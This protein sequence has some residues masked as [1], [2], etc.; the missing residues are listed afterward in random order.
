MIA[1]GKPGG[2]P[3]RYKG[4]EEEKAPEPKAASPEP[5][6][7]PKPAVPAPQPRPEAAEDYGEKLLSD[8]T[9]PLIQ[10]GLEE[11]DAKEMLAQIFEATAACLRR[12]SEPTTA[13]AEGA[14]SGEY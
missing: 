10:A 13:P 6:A 12:G 8:M 4:S 14:E 3:P 1:I 5:A 9:A 2:P 7:A 11:G